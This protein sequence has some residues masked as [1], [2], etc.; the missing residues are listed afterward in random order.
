[1]R[2]LSHKLSSIVTFIRSFLVYVSLLWVEPSA[3][4]E[5]RLWVDNWWL[6]G[7]VACFSSSDRE[8]CSVDG[9]TLG[10]GNRHL[11]KW[12]A[13]RNIHS[14]SHSDCRGC[15]Q[16][17]H[18]QSSANMSDAVKRWDTWRHRLLKIFLYQSSLTFGNESWCKIRWMIRKRKGRI[19]TSTE[20]SPCVIE[21][22]IQW[23][24]R[25]MPSFLRTIIKRL[26]AKRCYVPESYS[27][28]IVKKV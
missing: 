24:K 19:Q 15:W 11:V 25:N 4:S 28:G 14:E 5:A 12:K 17:E 22:Y 21:L 2:T 6:I 27:M 23:L 9:M 7:S 3:V 8:L 18:N 13:P 10:S 20:H 1:M 16:M 26:S